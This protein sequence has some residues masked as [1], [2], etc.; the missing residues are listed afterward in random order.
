MET[1]IRLRILK[2]V[3]GCALLLLITGWCWRIYKKHG[4]PTFS[5]S[6]VESSALR[7]ATVAQELTLTGH[8]S[9]PP[10]DVRNVY[11]GYRAIETR[12]TRGKA[13]Q[14]EVRDAD[15]PEV[16][17]SFSDGQVLNTDGHK[18]AKWQWRVSGRVLN[19]PV[20]LKCTVGR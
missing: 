8:W 4:S 12:I 18:I 20:I 15:R 1:K 11:G 5:R 19:A 14:Y 2:T 3:I 17:Y 10:I 9:E 6:T 13:T 7:T 16:T